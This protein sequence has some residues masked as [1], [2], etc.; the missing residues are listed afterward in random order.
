M[1]VGCWVAFLFFEIFGQLYLLI[2]YFLVAK[3]ILAWDLGSA[4]Y[5]HGRHAIALDRI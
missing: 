1:G 4:T 5:E 3:L 2:Q